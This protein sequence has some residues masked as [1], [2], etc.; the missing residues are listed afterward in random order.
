MIETSKALGPRKEA[1]NVPPTG[2]KRTCRGHGGTPLDPKNVNPAQRVKENPNEALTVSGG[3]LFSCACRE[4]TG[5]EEQQHQKPCGVCQAPVKE[6][7]ACVNGQ[8]L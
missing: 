8:S 3:R 1:A 2:L 5:F 7:E 4:G 6:E